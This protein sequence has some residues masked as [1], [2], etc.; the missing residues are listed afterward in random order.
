MEEL[1]NGGRNIGN[2]AVLGEGREEEDRFEERGEDV[3]EIRREEIKSALKMIKGGKAGGLDEIAVEMLNGGGE[4]V[5]KWL[6]RLFNICWREG[7]VPVDFKDA[8]IVPLFKG[9]GDKLKCENYRGISLLSNVGKVYGRV[10]IDRVVA[11]SE[12]RLGEEQGGFR[13]GRGCVDQIF[14]LRQ[15]IEKKLEKQKEAFVAFLDLE[16]AYD[17]VDRERLWNVLR[18]YG[19]CDTLV[20]A[21]KSFYWE[22][23]ACVRVGRVEGP[24]FK[25][26]VGL[27]QGCVMSPG[28]FNIYMDSVVREVSGIVGNEGVSLRNENG[29]EWV[30]NMLL[31]AD[32]T[33]LLSDSER[34]VQNMV[35]VFGDVCRARGVN[36]NVEKSKV[37]RCR[38]VG[39]LSGL[40]VREGGGFWRR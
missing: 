28:L 30:L 10:L 12:E 6:V 18:D 2:V 36:I 31:F 13:R 5:L 8:C 29:I 17:R 1:L 40:R 35:E 38:K 3:M 37:M 26:Q 19:V 39:G 14:G 4:P 34:G 32:D 16:K 20:R 11:V 22:G 33:V 27:R 25:V 9:K 7:R 15:I 23:R 24:M 21:V